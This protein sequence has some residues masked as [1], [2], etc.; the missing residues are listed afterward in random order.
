M[1]KAAA[2][3]ILT[4]AITQHASIT[5]QNT[6][7]GYKI[8][9]EVLNNTVKILLRKLSTQ[10]SL[11][12]SRM[13][14]YLVENTSATVLTKHGF[15]AQL[16]IPFEKSRTLTKLLPQLSI[17]QIKKWQLKTWATTHTNLKVLKFLSTKDLMKP[18]DWQLA[19]QNA[20]L[21]TT[22]DT[23]KIH[24]LQK[25]ILHTDAS[26]ALVIA[27]RSLDIDDIY[28]VPSNV[29]NTH[30]RTLISAID[31]T[32]QIFD[33]GTFSKKHIQLAANKYM[34]ERDAKTL[35]EFNVNKKFGLNL[36]SFVYAA[37]VFTANAVLLRECML[38]PEIHKLVCERVITTEDGLASMLRIA[39][40]KKSRAL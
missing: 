32:K 11:T 25:K 19:F 3:H 1:K 2:Q 34:P 15:A 24:Q 38:K 35:G 8:P 13:L 28:L 29:D 30:G 23:S 26:L 4:T 40:R 7:K 21:S 14:H 18:N 9:G 17:A 39:K 16:L 31:M 20:L 37:S 5:F 10:P 12:H 22:P 6:L 33:Y 36:I 27:G